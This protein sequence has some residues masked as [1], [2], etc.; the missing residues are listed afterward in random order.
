MTKRPFKQLGIGELRLNAR[1]YELV[2]KVLKSNRLSYGPFHQKLEAMFAKEHDVKFSLF[3]NS[4]TSA[5][6]IALHALKSQFGWADEDEVIV[7]AVTFVATANIVMA[8]RL[9]PVFVDVRRDT[10]NID[11]NL[12]ERAITPRTRCI[13]PVHL[14]GLPAEMGAIVK[15]ARKRGLRIIEDSCETMFARCEGKKVGSIGDIGCFSTYTAHFLVTGVGG[16]ATTNDHSLFL[17]MRS[18]MNHGRDPI[19]LSIDDDKNASGA[20]L[21]DIVAKRF[22]FVDIGYSYRCTEFEAALGIAQMEEKDS[23]LKSR[24]K[25]A[26]YLTSKLKDLNSELQLPVIPPGAEHVYMIYGVV[27][28]NEPKKKLVNFLEAKGI[29]TRDLF[30]LVNQPIYKKFF[31]E[32][33]EERFPVAKFLNRHAFYIGCHQY[34]TKKNLD[35]IVKTFY[36]YFKQKK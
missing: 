8:C 29:E 26:E 9:K 2:K 24:R 33:L 21:K 10:F 5:L 20:R 30:P 18:L 32:D 7:P 6:Q 31:G 19:Y 27:A 35:Y 28:K 17:K 11:P 15:I 3:T 34:F 36:N 12:I 13:I 23:I 25:N 4:G 1:A 22:R 16:F 14:L